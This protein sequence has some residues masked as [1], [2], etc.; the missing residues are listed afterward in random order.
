[1]TYD[2]KKH[3]RR[4]V[5]LRGWDYSHAAAYFVTLVTDNRVEIFG[6]IVND[7]MQLSTYG[8]IAEEYW[9][10]VPAHFNNVELDVFVVMPNHVHGIIVILDEVPAVGAQHA[11][12]L[13]H[14]GGA[15]DNGDVVKPG[16]LP[17][18]MRSY[19]SAVTRYI[20]LHRQT[21]GM[22]VWQRSFHD[23]II[24]NDRELEA[25]REYIVNSPLA[26]ALDAENPV[27]N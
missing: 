3:H 15:V 19:K 18:I 2:P 13:L 25:R 10:E 24:R 6:R 23:R 4:S 1:V 14:N 21:P 22:T 12:P 26:W 27:N 11:A 20:N 8:R 7:A 17:A 5:R 16:S 9:Q